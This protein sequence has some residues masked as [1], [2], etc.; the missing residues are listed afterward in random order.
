MNPE[1]NR[2]L[3]TAWKFIKDTDVSVF[4]TGKAGSGKTTFLRKVKEELQKRMVVVAPTGVAAINAKGMTI[5]SFFQLPI[6]IHLPE[7][8]MKREK[9]FFQM[10]KQKKNILRTLD[11]LII[12]EISMVR[13]DLLDAIDDVLRKYKDPYLPFGGVQL[14]MIGDLQQLAPVT[15]EQE[16]DLLKNYYDTPY[17]FS[18]KALQRLEYIAIELKKIYRQEDGR[19]ISLLSNIRN[20]QLD[21]STVAAL[22]ERYIPGFE[23]PSGT[24]YIRLTTHNYKADQYNNFKLSQL[25]GNSRQFHCEVE[26]DF[27]ENSYPAS[28]D[29]EL[30]LGTQVM[31]IRN[32]IGGERY[33]NGKIGKVVGFSELGI[34]VQGAS[35]P[36]PICVD[37]SE[38]ENTEYVV[39][40]ET[41][42][43][44]E[45]VIGRFRQ[46]PLRMAWAITV[47]K[48]QGLTFDHAILD[49]N[50][51]FAHGQ[52]YVALS[53]CRSL[54]GL[55]LTS[56]L[57]VKTLSKDD[58]VISY[59]D[60]E[61]H[62]A[63][64]SYGR[65][66]ELK[67]RY[68]HR[69][70]D[71]Q[72]G[73]AKLMSCINDMVRLFNEFLYKS[74]SELCCSWT[75]V[76]TTFAKGVL[77]VSQK[78]K[79]QYDRMLSEGHDASS[80][81]LQDRIHK[82]ADYFCGALSKELTGL[83]TASNNLA[84]KNK[85]T[86]K[87]YE[88]TYDRFALE[89]RLKC[90]TLA[91]LDGH[92][93]SVSDYLHDKAHALLTDAELEREKKTRR[94]KKGSASDEPA[95]KRAPKGTTQR[96]SLEMLRSGQNYNEI[97]AERMLSPNTIFGHLKGFVSTG[98][99]RWDE[100]LIPGHVEFVSELF[101]RNGKPAQISDY[102]QLL[103]RDICTGEYYQIA[104]MLGCNQ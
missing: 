29:L 94:S 70:L 97:A 92:D 98:E 20:G 43:I 72:F 69:L 80:R 86:L 60:R 103:P 63:E 36:V 9:N 55:V 51:S 7:S 28:A 66:E 62:A 30:K 93:F 4:L 48:S 44:T 2:E 19:F 101:E 74:H 77:D 71:E 58:A 84:I 26:G 3:E 76:Q 24:D 85:Q 96:L 11:L 54:E 14:L 90:H 68:F 83:A 82:A 40:A 102:N 91:H 31:F 56:P 95:K 87:R 42:E 64:Q 13:C 46:Y 41:K 57:R 89:L 12:D 15:N 45:K 53:R 16:W 50:Q 65:Y 100:V 35:D 8:Q 99:L 32:D 81:A 88:N 59:M 21:A 1:T 18:S 49:I 104:Q 47:H 79:M 27:P 78:F 61:L 52:V 22:N 75:A 17:F 25:P 67:S 33:F 38:W 73:F 37:R 10:S 34:L 39:D 5:H 23:A 6:G